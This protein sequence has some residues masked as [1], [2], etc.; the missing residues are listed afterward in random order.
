MF[1]GIS[2][3]LKPG[4]TAIFSTPYSYSLPAR[5]F[6]R[7]WMNWHT[8]YHLQHFSHASFRLACEKAGLELLKTRSITHSE[9]LRYQWL[10][11][12]RYP[13]IGQPSLFWAPRE[14]N[15]L[16]FGNIRVR[17]LNLM[18]RMKINHL[19]TRLFDL[20]G[21]GDNALYFVRKPAA[22]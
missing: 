19:L 11:S 10:H 1:A 16:S 22:G 4:G 18:H 3:V 6:G 21:K 9:W 7:T 12:L 15:G 13:R 14:G 20:L 2:Q 17:A 8:P 5:I